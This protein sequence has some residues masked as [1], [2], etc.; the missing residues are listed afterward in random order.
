MRILSW[1]K[2]I[3]LKLTIILFLGSVAQLTT[4]FFDSNVSN[5]L[6]GRLENLSSERLPKTA[7][8]GE[9][10]TATAEFGFAALEAMIFDLDP[11]VRATKIETS[12]NSFKDIK[13]KVEKIK[14]FKVSSKS[15][16]HLSEIIKSLDGVSSSVHEFFSLLKENRFESDILA[17]KLFVV[18]IMPMTNEI[19]THFAGLQEIQDNRNTSIALE[20]NEDQK[21]G[22]SIVFWV[23][24]FSVAIF[25]MCGQS[26][27]VYIARQM[28]HVTLEVDMSAQDVSGSSKQ[29][30]TN[31]AQLS[32]SA[33]QQASALEQ[34]SASLEE[35]AGMVESNVKNTE[36]SLGFAKN[37]K[38][39]SEETNVTIL[40]LS[41][42]MRE[43][44]LSNDRI[45]ELSTRI[46]E[47]GEKTELIDEIV[48]QTKILSFNA[49]VEAE[50]AGEMGRGFGVVAQEVG[51]LAA[52]SG[53][54]AIEIASIVKAAMKESREVI[55]ENKA[56]VKKGADLCQLSVNKMKSVIAATEKILSSCEQVLRASRE[57]ST[58]IRQV[59]TSVESLNKATQSNAGS[60][61][62]VASASQH[63]SQLSANLDS[64]VTELYR[65]I[66]GGTTR[67]VKADEKH[68]N[69]EPIHTLAAKKKFAVEP[70]LTKKAA[71]DS[72]AADETTGWEEI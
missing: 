17:R 2:G 58:G 5:L 9:V 66:D 32:S 49:S 55:E 41:E 4:Y 63:L 1:F 70:K 69:V 44:Q 50:R 14:T 40:S 72:F 54:S 3:K 34:A 22:D 25:W 51:N 33:Q 67:A 23:S 7:L 61:E 39:I 56:R 47:I 13:I 68:F 31:A 20:A 42:S 60:A 15:Q 29:L 59:S 46:E 24:F 36:D 8:F 45:E 12:E 48:F 11:K 27:A 57:Q 21:N 19:K 10:T 65:I 26:L 52:M 43:I 28:R 37:V 38:H 71:G 62:T 35:I 18:K 6:K 53:K 16:E 64:Q 30:S